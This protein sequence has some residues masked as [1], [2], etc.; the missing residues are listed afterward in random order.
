VRWGTLGV[1]TVLAVPNLSGA[2]TIWLG[3]L[4]VN[5]AYRSWRP[6]VYREQHL[7]SVL[8]ILADV[9]VNLLAVV[10]TTYWSSPFVFC[11]VSAV[12]TAGFAQGFGFAL[13]MAV[14]AAAAVSIPLIASADAGAMRDETVRESGQWSVE[15]LLVALVSGYARRL[16]AEAEQRREAALDQMSRLTE[17]NALLASLHR[18]AQDL[19]AS[20]DLGEVLAST[21]ARLR[22]L[23]GFGSA[24]VLLRD[25][26]TDTWVVAAAE[27]ARLDA[28]SL[29]QS[30]LPRPVRRAALL[31]SPL[32]APDLMAAGG[33]GL[34]PGS[35]A[36]L[37]SSLRSRGA[38][39]GLVALEYPEPERFDERDAEVL[40]GLAE[41]AALAIDN[42]RWFAKLRT[43][44]ADEERTRIARDLHDRIGQSLA[45]LAFELDRLVRRA[46]RELVHDELTSLRE[47]VRAVVGEMRETLYDLRSDVSLQIDLPSA[48]DQFLDRVRTRSNLQVQ[49]DHQS[50][51]RLP[52]NQERELWRIAQEAVINV[53]RHA[54]ATRVRIR[55]WTDGRAAVLEVS[56]DGKGFPV[57]KATRIDAYGMLGMRERADSIGGHL[58]VDSRV[59]RGTRV[60]CVLGGTR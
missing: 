13:R 27:G 6:I 21:M 24:A 37:Y 51:G 44:G 30:D 2:E 9:G 34:V 16:F 11:L 40:G 47:D 59:G 46:R 41:P 10:A 28:R 7:P 58:E 49:F 19:P 20:L 36:G 25:E 32:L 54:E 12:I 4:T 17:A 15:L 57:G 29:S 56:D 5:A 14:S 53:E 1:A 52:L 55:W 3:V 38:L 33:P 22:E 45:Y 48:L 18:L 31:S 43:V 35:R 8:L 39:L 23:I 60:R 50:E 42:A 26:A